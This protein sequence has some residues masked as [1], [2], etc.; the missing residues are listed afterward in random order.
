MTSQTIL[1]IDDSATIRKLVDSHLT[2]EGYRVFLAPTAEQGLALA[3]EVQPDLILLDHQLPGTTGFEICQQ[4]V[5]FPEC[6]TTPFVVSSTLRQQAYAEYMRIPNVVDS[7]H[8]PFKP[9][10]LKMTVAN[11]LETGAMIVSSQ[12]QGTAVP[13]VIDEMEKGALSGDLFTPNA[14]AMLNA[15]RTD[16]EYNMEVESRSNVSFSLRE[17]LDFLN[18]GEKRGMLEVEAEHDRTWFYVDR[19]R[20]QAV[21][22]A[23]APESLVAERLPD[24]LA[25][26][27]SLLRFTMSTGFSA[28]VEGLVD[29]LDK[30]VLDP[31]ILRALLRHQAAVLTW[32]CFRSPLRAFAFVPGRP[33]PPLFRRTPLEASLASLLVEGALVCPSEELPPEAADQGWNRQALRGQNLDRSGLSPQ[34]VQLLSALDQPLS[35]GAL[36][37]RIGAPHEEIHRVLEGFRLAD[38]VRSERVTHKHE[39]LAL[40]PDRDGSLLLRQVLSHPDGEW[41]GKVVRDPFGLQLLL[42]RT[43]PDILLFAIENEESLRQVRQLEADYESLHP[44]NICLIVPESAETSEETADFGEYTLLPRPYTPAALRRALQNCLNGQLAEVN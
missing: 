36:A 39:L 29:L 20:V 35:S 31:R 9:E 10:L 28:Q 16:S 33:L 22:S 6:A 41:T 40:E 21:L 44:G 3:R 24:S 2:Q 7:L 30:K 12:S 1:V 37:E 34:H 42:K 32:H 38:W 4:I 14:A 8:K 13:E 25:E 26:M 5:Q 19:G 11:A 27:A 43:R 17:V 15:E 18:N 23:S